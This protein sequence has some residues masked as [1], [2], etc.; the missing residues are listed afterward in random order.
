MPE[1]PEV[2]ITKQY[3]AKKIVG[4]RIKKIEILTEKQFIG[5]PKKAEGLKIIGLQRR[6]KILIW[7]LEKGLSLLIHLKLTGQL[8]YAQKLKN[9]KAVFGHPI[10]LSGGETLPGRTTRIIIYL[11]R[12]T[13]F[14]NDLR[15]FGWI[16]V[17][18]DKKELEKMGIEPLSKEFNPE[19][20]KEILSSTRRAIKT[21]LMDQHKIAG[22]G[23]IYSNESLWEA[24]I[25]PRKPA[26]QVKR[27]KQLYQAIIKVLEAGIKHGGSSTADEAY[28]KPDGEA[29]GYQKYF[30]VYQR[31]GKPCPRDRTPIKRIK[32]N[33]RS[34]F[35]CPTCQK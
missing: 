35:F 21:V 7:Q 11:D 19:R 13:V 18:K 32:I 3:L 4:R 10:P 16:K 14:F 28:I 26:N 34:T 2:E 25:D 5:D 31:E 15:K 27:I 24:R 30:K 8:V 6:A 20:L 29:G 1:L 17:V 12:G 33:N 22:I 23:N 9:E